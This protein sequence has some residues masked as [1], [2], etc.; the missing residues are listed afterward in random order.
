[1]AKAKVIAFTEFR[2][3]N[4]EFIPINLT[5]VY[6]N[7][8][9]VDFTGIISHCKFYNLKDYVDCILA[10]ARNNNLAIDYVSQFGGKFYDIMFRNMNSDTYKYDRF[11]YLEAQI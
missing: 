8:N 4:K 1:M 9:T 6:K 5:F 3:E 7:F 2:Y 10:I 11:A